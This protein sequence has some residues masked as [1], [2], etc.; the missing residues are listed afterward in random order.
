VADTTVATTDGIT[1][2]QFMDSVF[3][4]YRDKLVTRPYMGL[5]SEFPIQVNQELAKV[6]GDA[7]TFNLAG[8]LSGA[9]V[10]GASTLEGAEEA[11][12]YFAHRVVVNQKRNAVR[13]PWMSEQR[14]PFALMQEAK[15]ALTTWLA[16]VVEDDIFRALSTINGVVYG[17]ASEGQKDQWIVDNA[18]RVLYGAAV[19]NAVSNDSSTSLATID[20]TTDIL[21]VEQI[22]LAKRL[23]MMANPKI[24]PIRIQNGEEFFVLFAHPYCIRDLKN[25]TAWQAAQ[26]DAMPRGTDNPIFTGMAGI[27]DGVIIKET[28][29]VLLLSGV[30]ASSINVAMN[31]LC[32]AQA[33][34]FAQ[35]GTP[36]GF[37][38][39]LV[40][41]EFD[42]GD[43]TGVAIRSV[44]GI[45]KAVFQTNGTN[46]CQHGVVS[47]FSA[48]VA[49]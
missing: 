40:E 38:T 31:S 34:L 19:V 42:Y 22:S 28:P 27:W 30:G 46:A 37:V 43:K 5:T 25:T 48:A 26:R 36:K 4:E 9:G 39:D 35:A 18:D 8:A 3:R 33:L 12:N 20:G 2:E 23:A 32:G 17:S 21:N 41:E 47:V 14:A 29:K 24:R 16:Q 44:Y 49:D 45:E 10:T 13:I 1:A 6:K 7:I 15:P 11:Q